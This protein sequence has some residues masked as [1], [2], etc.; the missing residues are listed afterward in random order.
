V[1]REQREKTTKRERKD[2]GKPFFFWFTYCFDLLNFGLCFKSVLNLSTVS[3][4]SLTFQFCVKMILVVKCWM[5]NIDM[6]NGLFLILKISDVVAC[7]FKLKKKKK[8]SEYSFFHL[9]F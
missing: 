6:T 3:N 2:K 4:W 8:N 7:Q 5:K 1:K 9:N